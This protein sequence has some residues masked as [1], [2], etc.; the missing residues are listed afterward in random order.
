M[1]PLFAQYAETL[2]QS[3]GSPLVTWKS[4]W[5]VYNELLFRF[6]NLD[7]A[8]ECIEEWSIQV[9]LMDIQPEDFEAEEQEVYSLL[10]GKDLEGGMDDIHADGSYYM[11][12]VNNGKGLGALI[13]TILFCSQALGLWLI[14]NIRR[15]YNQPVG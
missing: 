8:T 14:F 1:T 3:M 2:Y 6:Q 15:T 13:C 12:G 10:K 4:A 9:D 11:G 7:E 5:D